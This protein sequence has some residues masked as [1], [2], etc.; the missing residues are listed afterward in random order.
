MLSFHPS[1]VLS[2]MTYMEN[3]MHFL[4]ERADKIR[5]HISKSRYLTM[6]EKMKQIVLKVVIVMMLL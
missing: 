6:V 3:H 1:D 2:I 4:K 5:E